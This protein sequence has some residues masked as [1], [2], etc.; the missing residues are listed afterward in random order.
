MINFYNFLEVLKSHGGVE[1]GT[2][3]WEW[4]PY[5][6]DNTSNER[7][8]ERNVEYFKLAA[9]KIVL[10][11]LQ[12]VLSRSN[13]YPI[14]IYFGEPNV[15]N[16]KFIRDFDGT[17]EYFFKHLKI[18]KSHIVYIKS[19]CGGDLWKPWMILHG[20][21][22]AIGDRD[23]SAGFNFVET[24]KILIELFYRDLFS[25]LNTE[26]NEKLS[27]IPGFNLAHSSDPFRD[28]LYYNIHDKLIRD[29]L[30]KIRNVFIGSIF[31]FK[32]ASAGRDRPAFQTTT[33]KDEFCYELIPWYFYNG[34]K[35]PKPST[36]VIKNMFDYL[37]TL[38]IGSSDLTLPLLKQKIYTFLSKI[39]KEV[40]NGLDSARGKVIFD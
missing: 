13:K 39:Q 30:A 27:K 25:N 19:R 23:D 36:S 1:F 26:H 21:G 24:I 20:I 8:Y 38:Q 9:H 16:G 5:E 15:L 2:Q 34:C 18:P 37:K 17:Q 40:E 31:T 12:E 35:I 7:E 28:L 29:N 33:S 3:G 6:D 32:S 11:K 14:H 4:L 22:H 10:P